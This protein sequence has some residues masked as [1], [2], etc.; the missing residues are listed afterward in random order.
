MDVLTIC[1]D[2]HAHTLTTHGRVSLFKFSDPLRC[3]RQYITI[4]LH[5]VTNR[6]HFFEGAFCD[7]PLMRVVSNDNRQSAAFKIKRNLINFGQPAW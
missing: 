3:Q 1:H 2:N 4:E 5:S 7:H 6:Q